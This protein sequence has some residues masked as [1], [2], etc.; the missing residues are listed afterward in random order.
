[1]AAES[2][3][4]SLSTIAS[5]F[6]L[7]FS[8]IATVFGHALTNVHT[9]KRVQLMYLLP[10]SFFVCWLIGVSLNLLHSPLSLITPL[11]VIGLSIAMIKIRMAVGFD[12]VE[13]EVRHIEQLGQLHERP[14]EDGEKGGDQDEEYSS[15][16][17][18]DSSSVR[19]SATF[20]VPSPSNQQLQSPAL[21]G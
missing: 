3:L 4:S 7:V 20:P 21:D 16:Y 19:H 2:Y 12:E 6:G 8:G 18:G 14:E 1:V 15:S 5:L 9:K 11:M 10:A 17:Q 13:Q